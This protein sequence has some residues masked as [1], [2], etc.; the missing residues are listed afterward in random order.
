MWVAQSAVGDLYH[1]PGAL[2]SPEPLRGGQDDE[3]RAHHA[4]YCLQPEHLEHAVSV[5]S[6]VLGVEFTEYAGN[7]GLRVFYAADAGLEL[8]AP[9]PDSARCPRASPPSPPGRVRGSIPSSSRCR[10]STRRRPAA[11]ARGMGVDNQLSFP[12]I[13]EADLPELYGMRMTLAEV[14]QAPA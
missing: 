7:P 5:W 4:V 6:Q 3:T 11:S 8:I 14:H 12:T 1:G 13:D 10:A 9:V 2:G